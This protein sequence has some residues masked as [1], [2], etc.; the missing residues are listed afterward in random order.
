M[1]LGTKEWKPNNE[2]C[3]EGCENDCLYCYGALKAA[4]YKRR[5]R[6]QWSAHGGFANRGKGNSQGEVNR[7][8]EALF[9][10]PYCHSSGLKRFEDTGVIEEVAA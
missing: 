3:I 5:T 10:S 2:N 6:D 9:F 7:H 4:Q 1:I 8:K